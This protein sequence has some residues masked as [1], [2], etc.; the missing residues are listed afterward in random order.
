MF[1][2]DLLALEPGTLTV[3][4]LALR[5]VGPNGEL[6]EISTEARTVQVKSLLANEP[7][8]KPKPATGPVS[9]IED[10]YTLAWVLGGLL[11]AA[12]IAALTWFVARWHARRPKAPPPPPPPRPAWEVALDKLEQLKRRQEQLLSAER[13]EEFVDGVSDALREYLGHR[14]GFE[15]LESTTEEILRT[16][17]RM[18]PHKLSLS[19]VSL[20]LEQCDLV[21]FAR[22]TPDEEQCDDLWNGAV[23]LVRSTTPA[24]T[25]QR[26]AETRS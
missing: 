12:S 2:L 18:R 10:D 4:A 7:N 14:Y 20:L 21:K 25:E 3:P 22:A 16:L 17:E 24:V 5:V 11:A 6:E 1:E 8:A 23:G 9:V 26:S 13:G 19:G 15:G